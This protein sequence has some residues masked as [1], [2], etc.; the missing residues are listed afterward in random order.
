MKTCSKFFIGIDVSKP[1][2]DASLL[3]VIDQ[4]KQQIQTLRF[5]NSIQGLKEFHKWLKKH[6]VTMNENTLL[7]I[8][9]TGIYHRLLWAFCC[10]K[11]LPIHIGNAAH[12]KWSF[13]IAR[14][15]SD[16]VDSIRLCQ[17]AYRNA[18]ELKSSSILDPVLLQIQDLMA[19]RRRLVSQLKSNEVY[20]NELKNISNIDNRLILE[21]LH[22]DAIKGISNSISKIETLLKK[23]VSE[24]EK[25]KKNYDLLISVPGIGH[26][27]AIYIICCT[28]NFACRRS[29][30]QLASYAGVVPFE[31]SS[32]ISIKGRNRVSNMANKELKK[33][34]HLCALSAIQFYPEF[35]CYFERK[36]G[37]GKH[38]MSVINAIRNKIVLR[39]A[40]VV[41]KQMPY[42]SKYNVLA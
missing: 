36:T 23:I 30:K 33:M 22:R 10:E 38:K 12:I 41:I 42:I 26:L 32:G 18:E 37:E 31:H 13:G 5:E 3:C 2:F 15:K 9:N 40:A 6:K 27:T 14:G 17:Y 24:N 21:R 35:K 16:R 25:I 4:Q 39:A 8:E 20:L 7:V 1:Y 34:L 19:S 11:N 28:C 29:G